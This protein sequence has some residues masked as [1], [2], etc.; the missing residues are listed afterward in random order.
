MS[1]RLRLSLVSSSAR[2]VDAMQSLGLTAG[3]VTLA[4]AFK[5]ELADEQ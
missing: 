2:I 5:H 4:L 3:D 1:E